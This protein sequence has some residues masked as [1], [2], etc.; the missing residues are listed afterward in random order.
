[1]RVIVRRVAIGRP[2]FLDGG[3]TTLRNGTARFAC[4]AA[5]HPQE[6]AHLREAFAALTASADSLRMTL[7]GSPAEAAREAS[8]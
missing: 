7:D 1:M 3:G 2:L 6:V 5:S 4:R 8:V